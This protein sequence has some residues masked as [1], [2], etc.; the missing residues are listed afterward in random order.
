MSI[1]TYLYMIFVLTPLALIQ[2]FF[3]AFFVWMVSEFKWENIG[4]MIFILLVVLA[5]E[6]LILKLRFKDLEE[7]VAIFFIDIPFTIIKLPLQ[8]IANTLALIAFFNHNIEVDPND[9]PSFEYDG[10][11]GFITL[12]FFQV[13]QSSDTYAM[14]QEAIR[15]DAEP[16][17]DPREYKWQTF[18]WNLKLWFMTFLHSGLLWL[19][20]LL[21]AFSEVGIK[22]ITIFGTLAICILG[23]ILYLLIAWKTAEMRCIRTSNTW[24]DNTSTTYSYYEYSE[25]DDRY[26]STGSYTVGPGYRGSL[27]IAVV[28]YLIT[29]L[30]WIVPQTIALIL[31]LVLPGGW[32]IL[33]VRHQDI[34][35]AHQPLYNRILHD[36]FGI[37][38]DT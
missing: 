8:L 36:L 29:G 31:S 24:Y 25:D 28:L 35:K 7:C 9:R 2:N 34:N 30:L 27:S 4:G 33:P 38:I 19:P 10:I 13:Q 15:R 14:H 17:D 1:K 6:L 5:L 32:V 12:N 22:T 16:S 11:W 23:P 3:A 26:I 37:I 20:L 18:R 21:F